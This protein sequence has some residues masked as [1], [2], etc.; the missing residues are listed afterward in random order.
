M[1]FPHDYDG[2][3]SDWG[4]SNEHWQADYASSVGERNLANLV[5]HRSRS[6]PAYDSYD[7]K[8]VDSVAFPPDYA[9]TVPNWGQ[10]NEHWQ[11]TDSPSV[12]EKNLL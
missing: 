3:V 5:Q 2:T 7:G 8:K 6:I 12:G 4:H 9:V 10:S 11:S 1:A